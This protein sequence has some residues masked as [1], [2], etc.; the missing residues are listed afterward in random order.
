MHRGDRLAFSNGIILL[1]VFAMALVVIFRGNVFR[2]SPL[3]AVGV[4]LSFTLS[5]AG[6][7][8][9]WRRHRESGWRMRGAMTALGATAT[10]GVL[11]IFVI[12]KFREGA[13]IVVLMIPL[14]VFLFLTIARHYEAVKQE[15]SLNGDAASS[16]RHVAFVVI[17]SAI[18]GVT[19]ETLRCAQPEYGCPSR[20]CEP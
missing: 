19:V 4:L 2:L 7:V 8:I 1:T 5:Q 10:L 12:T 20:S 17:V 13:W 15:L 14:G 9:H 16:P 3:Y 18:N 6:M 11:I